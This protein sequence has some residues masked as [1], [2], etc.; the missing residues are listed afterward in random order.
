MNRSRWFLLSSACG[1]ALVASPAL[2]QDAQTAQPE[3]AASEGDAIIVTARR[4]NE[5]LQDVPA[6]VAVLTADALRAQLGAV[7]DTILQPINVCV[8]D[9]MP[10]GATLSG[11]TVL[12]SGATGSIVLSGGLDGRFLMDPAMREPGTC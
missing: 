3:A 5:R 4:Q 12:G 7:A 9:R 8:A 1:L 10:V 11:V 2:A 6:S